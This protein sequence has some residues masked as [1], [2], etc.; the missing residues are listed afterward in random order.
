MNMITKKIERKDPC[1]GGS[2]TATE[3]TNLNFWL[4]EKCCFDCLYCYEKDKGLKSS[5]KRVVKAVMD[6]LVNPLISSQVKSHNI[7]FFGGEP[8]LCLDEIIYAVMYGQILQKKTG[9]QITFGLTTNG[10]LFD[11]DILEFFKH[12]NIGILLSLDGRVETQAYCRGG[13]TEENRKKQAEKVVENSVKIVRMFPNTTVRVTIVPET[14]PKLMDNIKFIVDELGFKNVSHHFVNDGYKLISKDDIEMYKG[15]L[16]E[17][18]VPYAIRKFETTGEIPLNQFTKRFFRKAFFSPCGAGK[19]F[20]GVDTEGNFY[21]CHRFNIWPEWKLGSIE[22]ISLDYEKRKP[23]LTFNNQQLEMCKKCPVKGCGFTCFASNYSLF[24][25][26]FKCR[27]E[28]CLVTM[29][30]FEAVKKIEEY[31]KNN[32][33]FMS[34]YGR[35]QS[36]SVPQRHH[37]MNQPVNIPGLQSKMQTQNCATVRMVGNTSSCTAGQN[38]TGGYN[39]KLR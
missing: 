21:P 4:T 20:L 6:W 31:F 11:D 16:F 28:E 25:D 29:L 9:K 23:F 26:I 38:I 8:L 19:G 36:N 22:T 1:C 14:L 5:D 10:Y 15:I 37:M 35:R 27:E 33:Y 32:V 24:G 17:E 34:K 7:N 2:M 13:G 18:L 3:I 39:A 12:Y 30:E